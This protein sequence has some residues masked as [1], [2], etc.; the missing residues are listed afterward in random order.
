MG[1][2]AGFMFMGAGR[3]LHW[4]DYSRIH[5]KLRGQGVRKISTATRNVEH[6][7]RK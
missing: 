2:M 5:A 6:A 4:I 3:P 1:G 7:C